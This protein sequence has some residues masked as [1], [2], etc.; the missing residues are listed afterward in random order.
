MQD[1]LTLV[2]A[3]GNNGKK[4]EIKDLL[5]GFPVHVKNLNDFG[6]IPG[7]Q[8]TGKTFDENA[9]IKA[10]F[11]A[12]LLGLPALAD[13]SGLVVEVLD[14]APGVYSARYA[15]ENATDEERCVKLLGE[16]EGKKDRRAAFECV[17]S[18]AVPTGAALTY[19]ARCDGLI[20][21]QAVG[22]NGFGYDPIFYYPSFKKTFA[23]LNGEE[24]NKVSHR[25]RAFKEIRSEFDKVLK[26][27]HQN[28]PIQEKFRCDRE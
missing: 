8:E 16:M 20:A 4:S 17:I 18:I 11:T 26:W 3:T 7:V 28:M 27:I 13:D 19:E 25:G 12:R 24:K 1:F 2:I 6:P 10:S 15:G 14:G 5:A 23:E 21:D 9:Y 22:E